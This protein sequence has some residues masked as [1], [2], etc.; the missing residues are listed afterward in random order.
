[1][2]FLERPSTLWQPQA[3]IFIERAAF[4]GPYQRMQASHD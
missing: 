4:I 3:F 1:M 2:M